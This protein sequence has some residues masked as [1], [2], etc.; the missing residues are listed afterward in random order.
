MSI[1]VA[2]PDFS[3][4]W[5]PSNP[6][7]YKP[8]RIHLDRKRGHAE[9]PARPDESET[10]DTTRVSETPGDRRIDRGGVAVAA[11]TYEALG[12]GSADISSRGA[13]SDTADAVANAD[14]P[15]RKTVSVP[16]GASPIVNVTLGEKGGT[17]PP[18][19][20]PQPPKELSDPAPLRPHHGADH[21]I[22]RLTSRQNKR[23]WSVTSVAS[24]SRYRP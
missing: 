23:H 3:A 12:N 2:L 8:R 9:E 1:E 4:A 13:D 11:V 15:W 5:H 17:A 14:L 24:A 18:P 10:P 22:S 19:K 16:L 7:V 20:R 6:M 21:A